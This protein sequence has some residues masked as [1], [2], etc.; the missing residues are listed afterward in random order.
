MIDL[1]NL[2]NL[3]KKLLFWEKYVF[4]FEQLIFYLKKHNTFHVISPKTLSFMQ[5]FVVA[6]T[7][8]VKICKRQFK[9]NMQF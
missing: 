3:F 1:K 4:Y 2:K 6:F 5:V 7:L 8:L 9:C